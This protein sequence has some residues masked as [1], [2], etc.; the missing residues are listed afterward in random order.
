MKATI[1]PLV[2]AGLAAIALLASPTVADLMFQ[3]PI[4]VTGTAG[5]EVGG[6][7]WG[8]HGTLNNLDNGLPHLFGGLG[9][10]YEDDVFESQGL[11][12][13]VTSAEIPPPP[14]KRFAGEI[15]FDFSFFDPG[16]FTNH[17]ID[18]G[19]IKS[20]SESPINTVDLIGPGNVFTDGSSIFWDGLGA[21]LA[22]D[23]I[24]TIVWTQIPAP[25]TAALLGVA[26]LVLTRRRRR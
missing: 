22:L 20:P 2:V 18:I 14:G 13:T 8:T 15:T 3:D 23:P 10:I 21:D 5:P 24:V 4:T 1:T 7:I 25:G 9:S 12:V 11:L 26:A 17:S 6:T 16:F 19:P